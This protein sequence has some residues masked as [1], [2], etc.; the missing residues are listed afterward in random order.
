MADFEPMDLV[1]LA[2]DEGNSVRVHVLG[3]E[4]S[5]PQGLAAE[6]VVE[7]PFVTGR[8]DLV[9]SGHKLR[10][11][12]EALDKLDAGES[13]AW[14]EL[15]RGPSI[16]VRLTGDRDCPEVVVDDESCSMVTVRVPV[17]LPEDWIEDHRVR[18]RTL[19][20]SWSG[21]TSRTT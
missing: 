13:A 10:A 1:V 4:P 9:L 3:P 6:I 19:L 20:G 14:M 7:T 15:S 11:W 21:P 17:V 18:L 16:A 12:A 8:T 2:D 5:W